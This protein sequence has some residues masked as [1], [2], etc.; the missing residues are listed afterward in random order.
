MLRLK[1]GPADVVPER[2]YTHSQKSECLTNLKG[3][4]SKQARGRKA[5]MDVNLEQKKN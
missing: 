1:I 3:Q 2:F 5:E 4:D